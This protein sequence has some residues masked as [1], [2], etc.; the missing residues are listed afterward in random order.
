MQLSL[1]D[2]VLKYAVKNRKLLIAL[3]TFVILHLTVNSIFYQFNNNLHFN[4]SSHSIES[5]TFNFY[6]LVT[7][8]DPT[9]TPF[10]WCYHK[11]GI[12]FR[13]IA[14]GTDYKLRLF[15]RARRD[16]PEGR[17]LKVKIAYETV[18]EGDL[19]LNWEW[20]DV[21]IPERLISSDSLAA[22]LY[23]KPLIIERGSRRIVRGVRVAKAELIAEKSGSFLTPSSGHILNTLLLSGLLSLIFFV[24]GIGGKLLF[25]IILGLDL[26]ISLVLFSGMRDMLIRSIPWLIYNALF[27]LLFAL[28]LR[29]ISPLILKKID[30]GT[31]K[32]ASRKIALV[33]SLSLLVKSG[34]WFIP[35]TQSIDFVFHQNMMAKILQKSILQLS[36][37]GG[38]KFPY[39][40]LY[41][42]I[43]YPFR[44]LVGNDS[45]LMKIVF[46]FF[47][48]L[49]PLLVYII[50]QK[51]FKNHRTSLTA[52]LIYVVLPK[53]FYI[54]L[55]GILAN[56]FGHFMSLLAIT[57]TLLLIRKLNRPLP[58]IT[59]TVIYT[60]TMVSHFGTLLSFI[61]FIV[62]LF[63]LLITK[64]IWNRKRL[65]EVS[66]RAEPD[67][68]NRAVKLLTKQILRSGSSRVITVF[69]LSAGLAFFGYYIHL[70]K[71][72]LRNIAKL[73]VRDDFSGDVHGFLWV[74][75]LNL[76]KAAQNI[77]AKFG[78]LPFILALIGLAL[79]LI[80][81]KT[82]DKHLFIYAWFTAYLV[83]LALA[84]KEIFFLR[85][86]LFLM[87]LVA[88]LAGF[89][90]TK[91]DNKYLTRIT[92]ALSLAI[93][94]YLW[95]MF[96][97]NIH[98]IT[99][100]I[101]PHKTLAWI[102]W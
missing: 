13:G 62:I 12:V 57:A 36:H 101:I 78:L 55:L 59:L 22:I 89:A 71:P 87:P 69:F 53:D 44:E 91:F 1:P 83:Q 73:L 43:L 35:F 66:E 32:K 24:G 50:T 88:V 100:L 3:F 70:L 2:K 94:I 18:F 7:A 99:S 84:L 72:T 28:L 97:G 4:I 26:L 27:V 67:E 85:F 74:S 38:L 33:S 56:G 34:A 5:E 90:L 76:G 17:Y 77:I 49:T 92:I 30:V 79:L 6:P 41:Y 48:G 20:Y 68:R 82:D 102:L 21:D 11:S 81:K 54:Y 9:E 93:S 15:L 42:M 16:N 80:R 19:T 51:L 8:D 52:M 96:N 75:T 31:E 60:L 39:P 29:L 86:E 14:Q 65:K 45:L 61:I 47:I 58:F 95:I 63:I 37:A 64:D 40:P 25:L 23:T 46:C 10:R 98:A